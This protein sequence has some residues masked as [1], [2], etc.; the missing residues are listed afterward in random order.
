MSL[1]LYKDRQYVKQKHRLLGKRF[2]YTAYK[3]DAVVLLL[4]KN[5]AL[6]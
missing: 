2:W 1:K 3:Y 4:C 6:N 5:N